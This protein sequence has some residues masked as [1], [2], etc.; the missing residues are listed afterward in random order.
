MSKLR[1]IKGLHT[2]GNS[3]LR[4]KPFLNEKIDSLLL[5]DSATY[6]NK[7]T[8]IISIDSLKLFI[9]LTKEVYYTLP[10]N[11]YSG[12]LD[13]KFFDY[14]KLISEIAKTNVV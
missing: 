2:K 6:E 1:T 7:F 5:N 9:L 13:F 3:C 11:I 12:T 8:T 14:E 4:L 10:S